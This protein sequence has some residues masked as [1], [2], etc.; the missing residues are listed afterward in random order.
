MG[1][2]KEF[3]QQL[4]MLLPSPEKRR[5]SLERLLEEAAR[6]GV[7]LTLLYKAL[8]TEV[9][10]KIVA[11]YEDLREPFE[12][13]RAS[14]VEQQVKITAQLQLVEAELTRFRTIEDFLTVG[15]QK[16]N[17]A[18][19]PHSNSS[20]PVAVASGGPQV[21]TFKP[22]PTTMLRKKTWS[23]MLAMAELGGTYGIQFDEETLSTLLKSHLNVMDL[24]RIP[25]E[26]LESLVTAM[27]GF[28]LFSRRKLVSD[29]TVHPQLVNY[30]LEQLAAEDGLVKD[31]GKSQSTPAKPYQPGFYVVA[32]GQYEALQQR[33]LTLA[34]QDTTIYPQAEVDNKLDR[35]GIHPKSSMGITIQTAF[36]GGTWS[37][38]PKELVDKFFDQTKGYEFGNWQEASDKTGIP[39]KEFLAGLDLIANQHSG[40]VLKLDANGLSFYFRRRN[41]SYEKLAKQIEAKARAPV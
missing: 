23:F 41:V 9:V 11:D 16:V 5:E 2:A 38:Y 40:A 30:L 21:T 34:P 25:S 1:V 14:L 3:F 20:H 28:E 27:D 33:I 17:A 7:P 32:A 22:S 18:L 31:L 19:E 13:Q 15:M 12:T 39:I 29:T 4:Y 36:F 37:F 8:S 24:E 26:T 35:K 6:S 10:G